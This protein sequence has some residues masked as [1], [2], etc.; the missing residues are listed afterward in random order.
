MGF[1]ATGT[2]KKVTFKIQN[3]EK[4]TKEGIKNALKTV[5]QQIIDL[6]KDYITKPPKTGRVYLVRIDGQRRYHQ[7]SAPNQAPANMTGDLRESINWTTRSSTQLSIAAGTETLAPYA[8]YMEFGTEKIV[9]R[10]YI[11]KAIRANNRNT[12]EIIKNAITDSVKKG[13]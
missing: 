9:K 8:G 3:I 13:R 4:N 5:G 12:I 11:G 6:S 7:A 2:A 10:P 1:K